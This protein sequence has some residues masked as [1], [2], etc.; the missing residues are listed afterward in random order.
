M[1]DAEA[2]G[3]YADH[4]HDHSEHGG[5]P[6][7]NCRNNICYSV[8]VPEATIEAEQ[9]AVYFQIYAPDT[10][11]WVAVGTGSSMA[12]ANIF[13]MYQDGEGNV[14]VSPRQ[15]SGHTMPTVPSSGGAEIELL[16][17]SGASDGWM[18][19]NFRCDNCESWKETQALN[20]TSATPMIGAWREGDPLDSTDVEA[21][22]QVHTGNVRP[23]SF[24]ISDA[25]VDSPNGNP[26]SGD[27]AVPEELN[28]GGGANETDS[29]QDDGSAAAGR[30]SMLVSSAAVAAVVAGLNFLL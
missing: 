10:F 22:I 12:N 24:N 27:H 8:A 14:T 19:A 11:S 6:A 13:V 18:V 3:T 21:D 28:M 30:N 2:A 7:V 17:G 20:F 23:F 25:H 29:G 15:A 26:F 16:G 5:K 9:G 4:G 1:A